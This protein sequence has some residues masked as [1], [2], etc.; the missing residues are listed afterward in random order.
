M[1]YVPQRNG[2]T[3]TVHV[4]SSLLHDYRQSESHTLLVDKNKFISYFP[5]LLSNLAKI[6]FKGFE[7]MPCSI[8]EF[9]KIRRR[10]GHTFPMSVNKIFTRT[11]PSVPPPRPTYIPH[12]NNV[13]QHFLITIKKEGKV[14]RYRPGEDQRVG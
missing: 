8:Y 7:N 6:Q 3:D 14:I 1:P 9:H 4:H 12:L 5:C 10:K 11:T 2:G 13:W